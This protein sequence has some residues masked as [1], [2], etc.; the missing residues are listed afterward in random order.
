MADQVMRFLVTQLSYHVP[1]LLVCLVAGIFSVIYLGR[2][3]V[4]AMLTLAGAGTMT[5]A[6]V[7][8]AGAQTILL[9]DRSPNMA[10]RMMV[11]AIICGFL[12]AV[13]LG[14]VV[15]AVFVGRDAADQA[16]PYLHEE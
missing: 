1:V 8:A 12:R 7:L 11:F 2:M 10:T 13:G 9:Q 14:L 15:A 6:I 5:F 4:P 3:P 16:D